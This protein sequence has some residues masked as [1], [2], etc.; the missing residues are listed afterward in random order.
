MWHVFSES[1]LCLDK[2]LEN[3]QSND[4]WETK[5]GMDQIIS[6]NYR[7]FDKSTASQCNSSGTCSQDS[8]RC[9]SVKKSNVYCSDW[10]KHLQISKK[11]FCSMSMFNDSSCG[12]KDNEKE[13]LVRQVRFSTSKKIWKKTT[14]IYCFRFWEEVV[15]YQW[16]Q[17]T[18]SVG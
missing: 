8:T 1:V 3:T 14:V 15:L 16:R 9:S 18:R 13:C 7:I 6:E 12:T 4:A 5:I 10:E 17:S 2:I 11:E